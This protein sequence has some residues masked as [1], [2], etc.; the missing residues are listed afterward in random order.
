MYAKSVSLVYLDFSMPDIFTPDFFIQNR[1]RLH[2]LT[3][4]GGPI[5]LAAHGLLQ[6]GGDNPYPFHQD[7]NFWYLT[8]SNEPDLILVIDEDEEYLIVPGRSGSREAFDGAVDMAEITRVSGISRIIDEDAGWQ[9]LASRLKKAKKAYSLEP[10]AP[11]IEAYGMYTNPARRRLYERIKSVRHDV[12]L[13]DIRGH[14]VSLRMIKQPP[15]IQAIRRAI[16]ITSGG[17]R[18]VTDPTAL[19]HYTYEFEIES[20]LTKAFR[21]PDSDGHAFAPI[22]AGGKRACTLHNVGNSGE[23]HT[24]D[25]LILD[26]GSEVSHYAADIT[27]TIA[28]HEPTKRQRQVFD[29]V[30]AVQEHALAL[31]KP[32]TILKEY[33]ARVEAF[34]GEKLQELGL[35]EEASRETIRQYYPHATSHFLGLDVHDV[36]DYSKPLEPGMVLTCEPG[37]YI[38]EENIGIR[39]EDDIL[40][41]NDG[42]EVM[43][44]ALPR[45]L[46]AN[47]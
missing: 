24:G 35:I 34:M 10:P 1:A 32:G 42:H 11:Y 12:R 5:I 26:V 18:H 8:G 23:L 36:G 28:T 17:L 40:I 47:A 31:L 44:S 7:S 20:D 4:A 2:E 13:Q 15:E 38:P 37:I 30:L 41:T 43:S 25:L 27:R 9:K 22:V 33:E 46:S 16:D 45:Q 39:V 19:K 14:L 21:T 29:A 3:G 6:R